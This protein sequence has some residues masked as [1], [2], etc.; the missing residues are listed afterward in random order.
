MQF[1]PSGGNGTVRACSD[2]AEGK[3]FE[4]LWTFALTVFKTGGTK[5]AWVILTEDAAR[6][7][8]PE[9]PVFARLSELTLAENRRNTGALVFPNTNA[10]EEISK[11]K[12]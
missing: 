9:N 12:S 3:G 6:W 7:R 2:V 10:T 1:S 5:P 4:S 11:S 8:R